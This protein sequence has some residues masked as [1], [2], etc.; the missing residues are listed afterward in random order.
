M[1]K[2]F[3]TYWIRSGFFTIFQRFSIVLFGFVSFYILIRILSKEEFGSWAVFVSFTAIIEVLRNGFIRNPLIKFIADEESKNHAKVYTSAFSLN[4][5]ITLLVSIILFV[6]S[7]ILAELLNTPSLKELLYI[8]AFTNIVFLF[9][10]HFEFINIANL[11]FKGPLYGHLIKQGTFVLY[12]LSCLVFNSSLSITNLAIFQIV[13]TLMGSITLFLLAKRFISFSF[14]IDKGRIIKMFHFGKYTF[15]SNMVSM[16]FGNIDQWMLAAIL[17]PAAVAIYNPALRMNNLIEVPTWS[18]TSIVFPQLSKRIK[19][20]GS[21]SAKY[22]YEKSVGLI[23][24]IIVPLLIIIIIFANEVIFIIANSEYKDSVPILKITMLYC[25][26]IPFGRQFGTVMDA[27]GKPQLN[28]IFIVIQ[29]IVNILSNYIFI[30]YY[31]TIGAAYGTLLAFF[32]GFVFNQF[33]LQKNLNIHFW[34]TFKYG[35][36]FYVEGWEFVKKQYKHLKDVY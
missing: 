12:I 8:Y 33:Y 2:F 27:T 23:L 4:L 11:D 10:S 34:R 7:P 13:S 9:F 24:C 15:A 31:G 19:E 32:T 28:F 16:I 30:V 21:K 35:L 6:T 29:L 1:S 17:S 25:L 14:V 22:L 18:I 3:N 5:C 36:N 20:E 26:F